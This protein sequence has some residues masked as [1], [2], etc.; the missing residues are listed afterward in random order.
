MNMQDL[1]D[2]LF[3]EADGVPPKKLEIVIEDDPGVEYE[4]TNIYHISGTGIGI[5]I[6]PKY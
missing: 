6:Q 3:R 1:L 4:I 2:K 5:D